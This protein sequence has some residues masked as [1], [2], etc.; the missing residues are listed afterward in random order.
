M[1]NINQNFM[2]AVN[3]FCVIKL[4]TL[5]KLKT[6]FSSMITYFIKVPLHYSKLNTPRVFEIYI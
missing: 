1:I 4:K 5:S 3:G 6:L 2:P